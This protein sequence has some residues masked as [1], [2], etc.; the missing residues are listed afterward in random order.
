M[1]VLK[2]HGKSPGWGRRLASLQLQSLGDLPSSLSLPSSTFI[3]LIAMD[4]KG[5]PVDD[6]FAFW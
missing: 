3:A 2:L 6:L 4:A 5:V 1:P